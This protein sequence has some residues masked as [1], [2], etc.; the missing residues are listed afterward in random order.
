MTEPSSPDALGWY[1]NPARNWSVAAYFICFSVF[2]PVSFRV[3]RAPVGY[4]LVITVLSFLVAAVTVATVPRAGIKVDADGVTVRNGLGISQQVP[5]PQV[6]QFE[7]RQSSGKH[8]ALTCLVQVSCRDRKPLNAFGCSARARHLDDYP[9]KITH[10]A[11]CL[12][13]VRLRQAWE[14]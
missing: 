9:A 4:E 8:G 2:F 14:A 10:A 5:W 11:A 12:E 3:L 7:V 1:R 13:A 6:I